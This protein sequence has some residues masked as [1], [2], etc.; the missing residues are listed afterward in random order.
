MEEEE[1]K[2]L[3]KAAEICKK[4]REFAKE[5]TKKERNL[6]KIAEAI[7]QKI[8]E[9]EGKPAFPCNL[10]LNEQAA[11]FTPE[12]NDEIEIGER[13]VLKVDFGVSVEGSIVDNAFSI[14]YSNENGKLVEAVEKAL[15]NAISKIKSGVHVKEIG[16]EIEN[17]IKSYGF[18][19]IE[20][21][22]GH[23]IEKYLL[24]A[25]IMMPNTSYTSE[26]YVL[27]EEDVFAI[28]PFAT[29][30]RGYIKEGSFCQIYAYSLDLKPRPLRL[31]KS[32]ELLE[33]IVNDYKTLPFAMRWVSDFQGFNLALND[34]LKNENLH[35]YPVLVEQKG[36]LV[37]QA[38]TT[39]I[40]E[41]DSARVLV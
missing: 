24:H 7:E 3:L 26:D 2:N 31:Q 13:D 18:R 14:D 4:A 8:I 19:P 15:E 36:A 32:R 12:I 38:E 22:S 1:L 40:I 34:L 33:R 6:L 20:N 41:K 35:K 17:T 39:V 28:E 29:N 21:L 10:S 16:R 9:I 27:K 25:G 23:S 5:I 30:G 37:S 11:H